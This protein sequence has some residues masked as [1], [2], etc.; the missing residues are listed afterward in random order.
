M[1]LPSSIE[2]EI[3]EYVFDEIQDF[4]PYGWQVVGLIVVKNEG[5]ETREIYDERFVELGYAQ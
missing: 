4:I 3:T 1:T 5:E 2:D